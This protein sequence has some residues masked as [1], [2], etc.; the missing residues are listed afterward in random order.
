MGE[1][2]SWRHL[3]IPMSVTKQELLSWM[4]SP[5][6]QQDQAVMKNASSPPLPPTAQWNLPDTH[7]TP[8]PLL[9]SAF[10]INCHLG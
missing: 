1:H 7:Q 10:F 8:P 9:L 3:R 5:S 6:E 4:K 2:Q